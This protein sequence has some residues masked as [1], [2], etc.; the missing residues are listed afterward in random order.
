MELLQMRYFIALAETESV[1]KAA[2]Q[3]DVTSS[4]LS[5]AVNKLESELGLELFEPAGRGIRLNEAGR[6]LY[7]RLKSPLDEID[8]IIKE[9]DQ[10]NDVGV[11]IGIP[12]AWSDMLISFIKER[13]DIKLN[14]TDSSPGNVKSL[15]N[16]NEYDFW[17]TT[18][19]AALQSDFFDSWE[20]CENSISL[21]VHE[22]H[23]LSRRKS[24]SLCELK[25]ES[26]LFPFRKY[27]THNKFLR[28]CQTGGFE[29]KIVAYADSAHRLKGV[30]QNEGIAFV[31]C[32]NETSALYKDVALLEISDLPTLPPCY[33][34]S[35]KGRKLSDNAQAFLNFALHYYHKD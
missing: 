22:S 21:A 17:I 8:H 33:I 32:I 5:K 9:T 26:F 34:C 28:L 13:P 27:E 12:T 31:E 29:P 4:C 6:T 7:R 20:L 23:P 3:L 14:T 16:S 24:V 35:R 1:T 19:D 11:I 25:D 15:F 18:T 10:R 30:S 2:Q